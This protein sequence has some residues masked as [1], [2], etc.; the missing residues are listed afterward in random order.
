MKTYK[1]IFNE[2]KYNLKEEIIEDK[3]LNLQKNQSYGNTGTGA[4]SGTY[5]IKKYDDNNFLV[6]VYNVGGEDHI[7]VSEEEMIKFFDKYDFKYN[8]VYNL[9]RYAFDI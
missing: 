4:H 8:S 3:I 2:E 5:N 6:T 7:K 1:S 9:L